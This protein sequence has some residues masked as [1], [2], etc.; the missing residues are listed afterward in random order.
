MIDCNLSAH[1]PCFIKMVWSK[2]LII[3]PLIVVRHSMTS[4]KKHI[5][6]YFWLLFCAHK[7]CLILIQLTRSIMQKLAQF[8]ALCSLKLYLKY[9][10]FCSDFHL[11]LLVYGKCVWVIQWKMK[12]PA[13]TGHDPEIPLQKCMNHLTNS[14]TTTTTKIGDLLLLKKAW[15]TF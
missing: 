14:T 2:F 3:Y 12:F 6:L 1:L 8:C 9:I 11:S 7:Q 4:I 5:Y 13:Q 10:Q 15:D